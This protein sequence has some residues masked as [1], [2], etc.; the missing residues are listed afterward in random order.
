MRAFIIYAHEDNDLKNE[1]IGHLK[2]LGDLEIWHDRENIPGVDWKAQIDEQL[3]NADV[4]LALV[5]SYFFNSEY[6]VGQEL[7]KALA[8][9]AKGQTKFIPVIVRD[10]AWQLDDDLKDI[11]VLP[12]KGKAVESWP[13]KHS[14]WANV[15]AGISK[16]IAKPKA[17]PKAEPKPKPVEAK[18]PVNTPKTPV[19]ESRI[20]PHGG[21][22]SITPSNPNEEISRED[23]GKHIFLSIFFA[24]AAVILYLIFLNTL[25]SYVHNDIMG[26]QNIEIGFL[27]ESVAASLA[28]GLV[29]KAFEFFELEEFALGGGILSVLLLILLMVR[30]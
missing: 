21:K 4:I 1:L 24:A 9:Y 15:V 5:S 8:L 19:T 14:A 30:F 20:K 13:S 23:W 28:I 6:I 26:Y 3:E 17:K 27:G 10:C 22:N 12:E 29:F 7:P 18:H 2:P 25:I 16:A 11:E